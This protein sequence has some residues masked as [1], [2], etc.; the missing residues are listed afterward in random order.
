MRRVL[1]QSRLLVLAAVVGLVLMTMATFGWAI[2]LSVDFVR[3]LLEGGWSADITV[4]TALKAIDTYLLAVVQLIVAFGLYELF[5]GDMKVPDW[6]DI[7]S[8]DDLKKSILDVLVIII[9]IKCIE[10]L[11]KIKE[12]VDALLYSGAGAVLILAVTLFKMAKN[13]AK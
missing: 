10:G 3:D 13:S 12:P 11:V 2:A 5:V 6:L 9:A 8:I 4:V 7:H 1:E